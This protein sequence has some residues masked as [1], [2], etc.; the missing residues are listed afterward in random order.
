MTTTSPPAPPFPSL[1]I[2]QTE[3]ERKITAQMD[4]GEELLRLLGGPN[5]N[6]GQLRREY[7]TWNS[8][9]EIMLRGL[10]DA[11]DRML[12]KYTS[13]PSSTTRLGVRAASSIP[14]SPYQ[15]QRGLRDAVQGKIDVLDLIRESLEYCAESSPRATQQSEPMRPALHHATQK[16]PQELSLFLRGM[17]V[18]Y[19]DPTRCGF[20]MMKFEGTQLHERI[21]KAA[22]D[23]CANH[24]IKALRAD[25]KRYA[26]DLLSN[27]RT[28]MHGCGFGIAI[29]ERLT[30]NDF[31]PNVS[32]EVG[33]MMAL[34]KPVCLL[35]DSTLTSLPTDLIGRLYEPFDTQNP[36]DS[37]PPV[38]KKWLSDKS[39]LEN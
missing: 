21:L 8:K 15:V 23:T 28:Y 33:Y 39:L 34:G 37:I 22:V 5:P 19:P 29:F 25:T 31:N 4:A 35:K 38:L 26:D 9:N 17:R 36:E 7:A 13:A 3:A 32:L 16:D 27:V 10:F 30:S 24:G 2:P 20:V 14:P 18:D 1:R 12:E 11:P 6:T